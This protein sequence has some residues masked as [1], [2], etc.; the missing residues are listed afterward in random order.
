M[1]ETNAFID[2]QQ[3]LC[4]ASRSAARSVTS[5]FDRHLRAHGLRATQFTLLASLVARGATPMVAL[6]RMLGMDRTTLTRN[7]ALLESHGWCQTRL[8]ENDART[9]L[10]SATAKGRTLAQNAMPA[11]RKAQ[12]SLSGILGAADVAVLHRLA[13]LQLN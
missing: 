13:K 7:L 2:C 8:D 1:P 10:V 6:A 9:H 12:E 5:L 3:C 4:L 11:W